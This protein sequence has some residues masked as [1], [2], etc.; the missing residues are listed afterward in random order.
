MI[1][2]DLDERFRTGR[3]MNGDD[4]MQVLHTGGRWVEGPV[5]LPAWRQLIWS[6]IPNDR[7][8][9]WDETSGAVSVFRSPGAPTATP[10]TA[11]AG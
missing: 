6:D 3:C 4:R 5:Y 10:W 9:R 2:R 1:V 11:R 7:L 8:L